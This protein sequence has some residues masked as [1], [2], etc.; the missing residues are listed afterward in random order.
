M[1]HVPSDKYTIAWFKLAE[2][3]ARGEREKA[4][5]V[6]RLLSHSLTDQAYACQ[7][8]GDLLRCFEDPRA[9]NKYN[10]ALK[11]YYQERRWH[12]AAGIG[13]QLK[14]LGILSMPQQEMLIEV[15][16]QLVNSVY[17]AQLLLDLAVSY[18]E[19]KHHE[20][21]LPCL[22]QALSFSDAATVVG[23]GKKILFAGITHGVPAE[24]MKKWLQFF[25]TLLIQECDTTLT[26]FMSELAVVS[27]S[28]HRMAQQIMK[29]RAK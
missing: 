9:W 3:I 19:H 25:V 12:E 5:G 2:C 26:A 23:Y 27:P 22:E 4:Y 13:E 6:Y 7:L 8:E 21:V 14:T 1:R 28:Y 18:A 29:A 15:H 10:Q 20:Q 24:D 17:V 11:I 16:K